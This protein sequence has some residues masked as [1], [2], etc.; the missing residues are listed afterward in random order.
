MDNEYPLTVTGRKEWVQ[1]NSV[2]VYSGWVVAPLL[3]QYELVCYEWG[4]TWGFLAQMSKGL[5]A[6]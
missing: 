3:G 5:R 2:S 6:Q 4:W 1:K